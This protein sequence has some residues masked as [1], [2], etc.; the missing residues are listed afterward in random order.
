MKKIY[1][2]LHN[3][4]QNLYFKNNPNFKRIGKN[5]K[6]LEIPLTLQVIKH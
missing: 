5:T 3:H 6:N 4:I 1:I 2:N